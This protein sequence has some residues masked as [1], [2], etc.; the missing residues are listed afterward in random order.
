DRTP[1][2][3]GPDGAPF[4]SVPATDTAGK[5]P[6]KVRAHRLKVV[7][8][9]GREARAHRVPARAIEPRHARRRDAV[10]ARE[11]ARGDEVAIGDLEAG[12]ARVVELTPERRS[13]RRPR[14]AVPAT[15][16]CVTQEVRAAG[17]ERSTPDRQ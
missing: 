10:D 1:I 11:V 6:V 17:V 9:R 7:D 4:A 3:P 13:H 12:D 14:G 2:Q 15:H 16:E 5:S 8:G